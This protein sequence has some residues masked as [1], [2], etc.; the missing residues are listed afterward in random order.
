MDSSRVVRG[1]KGRL[2]ADSNPDFQMVVQSKHIVSI[3]PV[4]SRHDYH[5]TLLAEALCP[6]TTWAT[7]GTTSLQ[8]CYVTESR[9]SGSPAAVA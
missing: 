8:K 2:A 7:S 5:S 1:D 9:E 4:S 6:V 3:Q